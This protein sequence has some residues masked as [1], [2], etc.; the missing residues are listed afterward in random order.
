MVME[1]ISARRYAFCD[2]SNIVSFPHLVPTIAEWDDYLPRFRGSK[3]DHPGENL[4][5]FHKCMLEHDF[6]HE[7]VLIKMFIFSLEE[8]AR[9]WCQSLLVSSI[10]SLKE[11]HDAFYSYCKRIYLAE[12]SFEHC[13][14]GYALYIH[15]LA[16]GASS[17]AD[18]GDGYIEEEE[19]DSLSDISSSKSILQQED[20]QQSDIEVDD[21]NTLDAF[22]INPNVSYSDDYD[23]KTVPSLFEDHITD[24]N[25]QKYSSLSLEF[26]HVA[27]IFYEYD[28]D[29]EILDPNVCDVEES[30][31]QIHEDIQ[32]IIHEQSELV[33]DSYASDGSEEYMDQFVDSHDDIVFV[34]FKK[35]MSRFEMTLMLLI[36]NTRMMFM[37]FFQ[38][39][40]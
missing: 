37:L 10:H 14:E 34:F 23:T 30:D 28:D 29:L 26:Y 8:H 40:K 31:Q 9:E 21:N 11:F 22:G 32:S 16:V 39:N 33:Y 7:D 27:P 17:S 4:L 20:F 13:C 1:A 25:F 5:N 2:F 38:Q 35:L 24:D 6:F 15:N 12:K 19:E 18:E 3:Y 36:S